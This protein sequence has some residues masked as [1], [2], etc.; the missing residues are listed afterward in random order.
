MLPKEQ[1][2]KIPLKYHNFEKFPGAFVIT[3]GPER[4]DK[5]SYISGSDSVNAMSATAAGS[6]GAAAGWK[7]KLKSSSMDKLMSIDSLR[8]SVN[9]RSDAFVSTNQGD[10][11]FDRM[12]LYH[13][14]MKNIR[15]YNLGYQ[16]FDMDCESWY[17]NYCCV[18]LTIQDLS[19]ALPSANVNTRVNI[20]G[21]ITVTNNLGYQVNGALVGRSAGYNNAHGT[22]VDFK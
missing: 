6:Y 19:C 9:T 14:T 5:W 3:V 18:I 15:R 16:D 20:H 1:A 13:I 10:V 2:L 8:L 22:A 4:N 12:Q 7:D 11:V 17:R 21:S